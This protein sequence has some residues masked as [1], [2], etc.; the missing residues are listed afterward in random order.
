MTACG[1]MFTEEP[2]NGIA[3]NGKKNEK[4]GQLLTTGIT[5]IECAYGHNEGV[6]N[7]QV[8]VDAGLV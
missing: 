7:S 3:R 4:T 6:V 5:R 2:E 8:P 1:V